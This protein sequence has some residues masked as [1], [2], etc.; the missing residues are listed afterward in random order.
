MRDSASAG[1]RTSSPR[2]VC[3]WS[4]AA[5]GGR[6]SSTALRT[7]WTTDPVEYK[8]EFYEIPRGRV[9][10]RPV[11]QPHPP[12]LLGGAAEPALKRA[13]RIADGWISASRFPAAQ[14]PH[15]VEVIRAAASAAGRDT[16]SYRIIIRA[17]VRVRD[18]DEEQ[19]FTGTVEKIRRDFE[20][21]QPTARPSCSSTSTSTNRS[22]L[23]SADPAQSMRRAHEA[24]EAFAPGA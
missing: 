8:G 19:Q 6:S 20:S 7:I 4:D 5:R 12:I 1:A 9:D 16:S 18:E 3:R 17:V 14:L 11:Q 10:P 13:G 2:P 23:P 15:A 21:Y 22:A 24:L